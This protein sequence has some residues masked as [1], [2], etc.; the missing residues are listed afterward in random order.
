MELATIV[1]GVCYLK[2]MAAVVV[3]NIIKITQHFICIRSILGHE[4]FKSEQQV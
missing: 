4:K 1:G 2:L 3:L